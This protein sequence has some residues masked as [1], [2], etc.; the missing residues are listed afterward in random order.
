MAAD[1]ALAMPATING[2]PPMRR[3]ATLHAVLH[4]NASPGLRHALDRALAAVPDPA[5]LTYDQLLAAIATR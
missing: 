1:P 2:E 5:T 4:A 3:I